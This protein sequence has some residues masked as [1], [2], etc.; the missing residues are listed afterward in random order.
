MGGNK[1]TW[2]K[3]SLN[4]ITAM[5]LSGLWH[6]ASWNFVIWG[7]WHGLALIG[8]TLVVKKPL[9]TRVGRAL[10][11]LYTMLIVFIGWYFFRV[12]TFPLFMNTIEAMTNW[13]LLPANM[14]QFSSIITLALP[15]FLVELHQTATHSDKPLIALP[16]LIKYIVLCAML[17]LCITFF[18]KE[19]LTFIYF[20]F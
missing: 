2:F 7:L 3:V 12:T 1:G 14:Y 6:G 15:I 16:M 11:W 18:K 13:E 20:Q 4:L 8:Y 19:S 17:I 5:S 10:S 9:Q